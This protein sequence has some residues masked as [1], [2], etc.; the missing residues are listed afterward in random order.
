MALPVAVTRVDVDI[1]ALNDNG[2]FY[3][4]EPV[5]VADDDLAIQNVCNLM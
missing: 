4:N 1:P 5:V 3:N 2:I